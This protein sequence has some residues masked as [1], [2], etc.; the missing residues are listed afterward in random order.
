MIAK[1]CLDL[2]AVA[3]CFASTEKFCPCSIDFE[4]T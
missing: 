3:S 2:V 4:Q 1:L